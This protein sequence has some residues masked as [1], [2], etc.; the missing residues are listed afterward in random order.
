MC[1]PLVQT[2]DYNHVC[3]KIENMY[4]RCIKTYLMQYINLKLSFRFLPRDP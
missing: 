2:D 4:I 1:V 3:D